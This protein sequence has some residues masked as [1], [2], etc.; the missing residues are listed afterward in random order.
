MLTFGCGPG[1]P[2]GAVPRTLCT[3][4][5][6]QGTPTQSAAAAPAQNSGLP[7]GAQQGLLQTQQQRLARG[8]RG[9]GPRVG[10]SPDGC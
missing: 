3:R 8:K 6:L 9:W 5:G 1:R 7:G 2:C 4:A 10:R